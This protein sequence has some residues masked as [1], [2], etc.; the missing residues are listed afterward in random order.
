MTITGGANHNGGSC[1][2]SLSYDKGKTWTVIHSYVGNCPLAGESSFDFAVPSD[3][4]SGEAVF[5]WSWFNKVGNR[6]MYQNCASVTIGG[7]KSKRAASESFKSRPAM[8]VANVGNGCGTLEGKDLEFPD[9]GP[10]VT[11]D[12]QGTAPP[13]GKCAGGSGGGSGGG[14]EGG[15]A[16]SESASS[17]PAESTTSSSTEKP[18]ATA[19]GGV[20][21][22]A[23]AASDD[24]ASSA[25][26]TMLT[27]T[28][29][30]V[31]PPAETTGT[32][33]QPPVEQPPAT[34]ESPA[35][36]APTPGNGGGSSAGVQ[37]QGQACTKEGEWNCVNDGVQFQ[38]CASGQWS[39]LIPM[40][41]GT[42][43]K[44]G[45]GPNFALAKSRRDRAVRFARSLRF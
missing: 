33:E 42:T 4:P 17:T 3:A 13:T 14:D 25:P 18:S 11:K 45:M 40:A 43:C 24:S 38:R 8:F 9:P 37:P 19:P 32:P 27:M 6:E 15:N 34:E 12:S 44:E 20:F 10:D 41:P 28:N 35:A 39:A 2:A 29:P 7:G 31:S 1:Q 5:S 30:I 21:I 22:T 26:T 16:T 23:P 36:P